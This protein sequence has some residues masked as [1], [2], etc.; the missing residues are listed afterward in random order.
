MLN[1]I[2][3]FTLWDY[4]NNNNDYDISKHFV[5]DLSKYRMEDINEN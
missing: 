5:F 1:H 3:Y 2:I 4:R